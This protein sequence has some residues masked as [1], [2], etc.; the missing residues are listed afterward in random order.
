MRKKI[1]IYMS[2]DLNGNYKVGLSC[3]EKKRKKLNKK[4]F[5]H[6]NIAFKAKW[7]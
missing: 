6:D 5:L 7:R 3:Q 4:Y 1:K 2:W